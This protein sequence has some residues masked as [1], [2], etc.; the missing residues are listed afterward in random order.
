M[1]IV[2]RTGMHAKNCY[3]IF[4][5][6]GHNMIVPPA[7]QVAAP[8]GSNVGGV[9][10]AF[11]AIPGHEDCKYDSWLSV[12]VDDGNS[13]NSISSIGI[14][15][16][17]WSLTTGLDVDDGAVFWMDPDQ[18]PDGQQVVAQLTLASDATNEQRQFEFS[19]QGRLETSGSSENKGAKDNWKAYGIGVQLGGTAEPPVDCEGHWGVW[20]QCNI[21]GDG[22]Q[23]SRVYKVTREAANGGQDCPAKD[24]AKQTTACKG[25]RPCPHTVVPRH[26]MVCSKVG[27]VV[28]S[29]PSSTRHGADAI[30]EFELESAQSVS[31][32][33]QLTK[34]CPHLSVYGGTN[35]S[36]VPLIQNSGALC[37]AAASGTLAAG[38]YTVV[39]HTSTPRTTR[40]QLTTF[41]REPSGPVLNPTQ[42]KPTAPGS[43]LHE[44]TDGKQSKERSVLPVVLVGCFVL[45]VLVG[46][47]Y[48][49][50]TKRANGSVNV[51][52]R[53]Q[54]LDAQLD[55]GLDADFEGLR[56]STQDVQ[57]RET[58]AE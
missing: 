37:A 41:C 6:K 32:R 14:D 35:T 55:H 29:T 5:E 40:V 45:S 44:N 26:H 11:W 33:N 3:S 20:G 19:A 36:G 13:G 22:G 54:D 51:N 24:N 50:V 15:F 46:L 9:S 34:D 25:E 57:S 38:G 39:A 16:D 23:K 1:Y 47:G 10:P 18:A 53:R 48:L 49:C 4:G 42:Q 7:R 52:K 17:S 28:M 8:F 31:I 30:F 2:L 27:E 58:Y 12:G 43:N 21:C 56:F